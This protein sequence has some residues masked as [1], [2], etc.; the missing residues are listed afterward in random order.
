MD[1]EAL[2]KLDEAAA[3]RLVLVQAV[4]SAD[5]AGVVLAEGDIARAEDTVLRKRQVPRGQRPDPL[6]YLP[7]RTDELLAA[8][9]KRDTRL[10]QLA[11]RDPWW[12]RLSVV[13]PVLAFFAGFGSE[14]L[15]D[16]RKLDLVSFPLVA[17][18]LW[19]FAVYALLLGSWAQ[20]GRAQAIVDRLLKGLSELPTWFGD[21]RLARLRQSVRTQFRTHWW[22]LAGGLEGARLQRVLHVS[23]ACWAIGLVA[24]VLWTGLWR[25]FQFTWES[26]WLGETGMRAMMAVISAPGE[27]LF[28]LRGFSAAE[29]ERLRAGAGTVVS[30]PDAQRW[31]LL[32]VSFVLVAIVVPRFLLALASSW[33]ARRLARAMPFSLDDPYLQRVMARVSPAR[34]VIHVA[35]AGDAWQARLGCIGR[36]ASEGGVLATPQGDEMLAQGGA[37]APDIAWLASGD[38]QQL[39]AL[40]G[41]LPGEVPAVVLH[42]ESADVDAMRGV[43]AGRVGVVEFL[44]M[45]ACWP[46]DGP[47]RAQL[48]ARVAPWKRAGAERLVQAWAAVHAS[49]WAHITQSL[50]QVL[51]D[52]AQDQE[53]LEGLWP[54]SKAREA[55]MAALLVR[56]RARLD[57]AH[58]ELL[59]LHGVDSLLPGHRVD[60]SDD[61]WGALLTKGTVGAAGALAG[62]AAGALAGAK[63]DLLTGGLT[64][65]AGAAVGA[66]VGGAGLFSAA[67][68]RDWGGTVRFDDD[69][70]QS[71]AESLV[72][73]VLAVIHAGRVELVAGDIPPQWR[74]TAVAAVAADPDAFGSAWKRARA[75]E[76]DAMQDLR[77]AIGESLVRSLHA[78]Y[79]GR[80]LLVP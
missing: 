3:R 77:A 14:L 28:G 54:G 21:R 46:L 45:P 68:W 51:R 1:A 56:L 31:A 22:R 9:E 24:W 53:K 80:E 15:G 78:L 63:I 30:Q 17:F 60:A 43:P 39:R 36:Q 42:P 50:A 4:E 57:A 6:W 79:P 64:M 66:L 49:R 10:A 41:A 65:G 69:Q 25:R 70:L 2:L 8:I 35:A 40:L 23:A 61:P 12:D 32:Y 76:P 58:A 18:A 29:I 59:R 5:S 19:N 20:R 73:Q 67:R 72:L 37:L 13:L 74:S 27:W 71:I 48:A 38:A 55:A 33:R 16:P 11:E 34:V 52:S 47:L 7:A 26:T 44:T 62:A 75:G